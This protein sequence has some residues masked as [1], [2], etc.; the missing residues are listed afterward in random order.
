MPP[1]MLRPISTLIAEKKVIAEKRRVL[2]RM[3][4]SRWVPSR[5]LSILISILVLLFAGMLTF[6][7]VNRHTTLHFDD[8]FGLVWTWTCAALGFVG[9]VRARLRVQYYRDHPVMVLDADGFWHQRLGSVIPWS[10]VRYVRMGSEGGVLIGFA[11]R[12]FAI[13]STAD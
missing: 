13:L 7:T 2:G 4:I 5:D 10:N 6:R 11:Q 3:E 8:A 9:L 1:A 12:E